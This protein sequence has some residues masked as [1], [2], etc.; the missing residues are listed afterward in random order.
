MIVDGK[1]RLRESLPTGTL[2]TWTSGRI[3]LGDEIHGGNGWSGDI[4][5]AVVM[6]VGGSLDYVRPGALFIPPSYL[7]FPD[8]ITPFPPPAAIEWFILVLHLFS[9]ILVG[10]LLMWT[11]RPAFRVQSA[12]IM[13]FGLAVVL[14]LGKFLFD[15]RH[16]SAADLVVQLVGGLVGAMLGHWALRQATQSQAASRDGPDTLAATTR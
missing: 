4:R 6:T 7:Y 8:H 1:V 5:R 14:A 15:G 9:F 2:S 3:A 13:A 12:T 16:T 10:F 11:S